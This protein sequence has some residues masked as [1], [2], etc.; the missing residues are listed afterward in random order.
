MRSDDSLPA[1]GQL[2]DVVEAIDSGR[3]LYAGQHSAEPFVV[4]PRGQPE[5]PAASPRMASVSDANHI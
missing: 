4:L 3:D 1:A 5:W 2:S